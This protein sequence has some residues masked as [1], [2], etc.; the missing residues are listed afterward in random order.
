MHNPGVRIPAPLLFLASLL[1]ALALHRAGHGLYFTEDARMEVVLRVLGQ[2]VVGAG[3]AIIGWSMWTFHGAHT[4]IMPSKAASR[5]VTDGPYQ[6]SRNPM[7]LSLAVMQPGLA[8]VYNSLWPILFL[9]LLLVLIRRYLMARE[10]RY[11]AEAF[12]SEY[13]DYCARVGRWF[14]LGRRAMRRP[15]QPA[16]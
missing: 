7:Y 5:L 10:E 13:V 12:G 3:M 9:P 15:A 8:L 14:S 16:P 6:Y 11:L 4:A 1:L 2:V